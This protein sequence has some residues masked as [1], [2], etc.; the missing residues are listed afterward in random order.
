MRL[1]NRK[2]KR[3]IT[4]F[5]VY[6][7]FN[8]LFLIT[9]HRETEN[10]NVHTSINCIDLLLKAKVILYINQLTSD[11]CTPVL[12]LY[13]ISGLTNLCNNFFAWREENC[14]I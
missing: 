13:I 5:L 11:K 6:K 7:S 12:K 9:E 14:I 10:V 3:I 2:K 1:G 8:P 4:L